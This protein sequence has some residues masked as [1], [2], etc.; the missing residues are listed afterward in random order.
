MKVVPFKVPQTKNE[1]F[2]LQQDSLPHFY[3]RLHQH[4]EHQ[5][6]WIQKSEG[7]LIIGDYVGRFQPGDIFFLGGNQ[8]H[9][10][11]ND[12]HYFL[13]KKSNQAKSVS[14][15]FNETYFGKPFWELTEMQQ[16]KKLS[17]DAQKGIRI[18]GKTKDLLTTQLESIVQSTGVE[19]LIRFFQALQIIQKGKN[20]CRFLSVL[21]KTNTYSTNEGKR[22]N[23]ILQF[24]FNNAHRKI[25]I[26]EVA[27]I[28]NLS[29]EAFCR[30][31]K[32]RT[33]KTY[34]T[35]LNEVRVSQ[36]SQLLINNKDKSITEICFETG[37]SNVSNFNRVFKR[38]T[39]KTPSQYI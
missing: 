5:I 9:V 35:F 1:A 17:I 10:F 20:D 12:E 26:D 28:A 38:I 37:F 36:A 7:T 31:F 24:T 4:D 18:T 16:I 34:T 6:M 39:G 27:Q 30:Y 21:S 29:T 11:R 25:Y 2:R 19:K 14:I 15:Y 33:M 32:T 23:N 13:K 3:D 22:M 8:A